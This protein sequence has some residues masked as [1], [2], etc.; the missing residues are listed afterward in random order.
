MLGAV[1]QS[2]ELRDFAIADDVVVKLAPGFNVLTGETGAGKSL[3]IDALALAIG[4][5]AESAVVRAG[6]EHA[7]VQLT[8]G[9]G[10]PVASAARRVALSGRNLARLDG[11]VVTVGELQA[12]L[13]SVVGIFGQHAFR[14]LLEGREQRALLDRHLDP[15]GAAA[16]RDYAL[17]HAAFVDIEAR[18]RERRAA[19]GDRERRL[20]LLRYQLDQIDAAAPR[21]GE[22]SELDA[23]L[24]TLRHAERVRQG[25]ADALTGLSVGDPAAL[26]ALNHARRALEG[27]ARH[28]AA[29]EPLARDLATV[30][31][32]A[33]AVASELEAFLD[34]FDADPA[35]L[36]RAE[37][38]RAALDRLFR[39]YGPDSAT[40]L[41][42]RER[43][44]AELSDLAAIESD[45]QALEHQREELRAR[46]AGAAERLSA[47]RQRASEALGP[48]VSRVLSELA[49]DGAVF[50]VALD[51]LESLG[52]HGAESVTFR[53][54]ANV[55][56]PAA[57]LASV[58][59]GGELSRVMLALHTAAGSDRPV[60]AFDEVDAG[61][62]G[63]TGRAVGRLLRRLAQGRQVLVVTHLA[64]VA[65]FADHHLHV[66]KVTEEGRTLT[67][68]TELAGEDRVR[69]LARMLAGE[70]GPTARRHAEELIGASR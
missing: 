43:L 59:S 64:Q 55:G 22:E 14:T 44:A 27:A 56:E 46:R 66:A 15:A 5:R 62:G 35:A 36:D 19:A 40:V 33:N 11:E 47:A 37:A 54:A 34:G 61:V 12:A 70:D 6:A 63:G 10:A 32:G 17:A 67:R 45:L 42:E 24:A 16:A 8:F 41:A 51:P 48:S 30:V 57:P 1:L 18:L 13:E 31:D 21:V 53:L 69:E 29:L 9:D 4:G 25:A 2:I 50:D 26:D 49:L 60:L 38:R 65:A 28:A 58:A 52:T 20:E 68:I 3:V 23:L 39:T 7:L